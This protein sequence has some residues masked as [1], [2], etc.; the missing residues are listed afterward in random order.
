MVLTHKYFAQVRR[1]Q[2][3]AVLL[4]LGVFAPSAFAQGFSFS[5]LKLGA[6]NGPDNRVFTA[7]D[8][9]VPVAQV[10]GNVWYK[11]T[12]RDSFGAVR[13]SF[14]CTVGTASTNTDNSYV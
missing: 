13:N 7:G 10:P 8:R 1:G 14:P 4:L 11:V 6:T 12:V 3:L 5:R 9:V 2:F